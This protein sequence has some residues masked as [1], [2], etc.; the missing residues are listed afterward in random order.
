MSV[1][2]C[3]RGLYRQL[4]EF[5]AYYSDLRMVSGVLIPFHGRVFVNGILFAEIE[6]QEARVNPVLGL[7]VFR[8]P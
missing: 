4:R 1:T 8:L 6:V 5:T 7:E 3:G 2:A